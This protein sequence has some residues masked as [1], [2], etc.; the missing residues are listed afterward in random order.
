MNWHSSQETAG[1]LLNMKYETK[2]T[3]ELC[4]GADIDGLFE[5]SLQDLHVREASSG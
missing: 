5:V 3:E 4:E 2:V 1:Y